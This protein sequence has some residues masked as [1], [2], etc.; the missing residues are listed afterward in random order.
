MLVDKRIYNKTRKVKYVR[1]DDF[2]KI[3]QQTK[4]K[5][6]LASNNSQNQGLTPYA[7]C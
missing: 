1:H 4:E 6:G 5:N 2:L 3:N 7:I